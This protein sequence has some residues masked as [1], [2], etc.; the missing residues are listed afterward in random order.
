MIMAK[1]REKKVVVTGVSRDQ[2]ESSFAAF[3]AADAMFQNVTSKMDVEITRIR[4]KY[5]DKLAVLQE[6]KD[7]AFEVMNVYAF[8]NK[9]DLFAKKK[10][11]ETTHGVFGFRTGTPKLKTLRGFTWGAV[12][13]LLKEF[14]PGYVR[15]SEEPAKDKLLADRDLPEIAEQFQRVGIEVIQEETFFVEPKK[16]ATE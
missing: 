16:E 15:T 1:T 3:A 8:E 5:Q 6:E 14:L 11:L 7:R 4:E 13:N 10:S 12:T 9:D 2:F